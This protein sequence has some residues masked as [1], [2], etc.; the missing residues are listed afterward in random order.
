MPTLDEISLLNAVIDHL[1]P[2]ARRGGVGGWWWLCPFC[3]SKSLTL[4]VN[5]RNTHWV[6]YQCGKEGDVLDFIVHK[7]GVDRF[8]ASALLGITVPPVP[9][10]RKCRR[11]PPNTAG[12]RE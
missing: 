1:G 12:V 11:M 5:S 9:T 7:A 10:R 3:R 2:P 8:Q 4:H 6:C